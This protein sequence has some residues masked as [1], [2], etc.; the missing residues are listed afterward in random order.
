V[1]TYASV[2]LFY[3]SVGLVLFVSVIIIGLFKA[4]RASRD[5]ARR[6]PDFALL[7]ISLVACLLG[8]LLM[9]GSASLFDSY[10][11]FLYLLAGLAA[12]YAYISK[13]PERR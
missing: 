6:D 1:H 12:A 4:Y 11:K 7:G 10:E 8:T 3:G 2:T 13:F 5:I 9:I